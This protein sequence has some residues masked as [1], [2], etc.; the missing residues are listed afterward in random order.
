MQ[1]KLL[2][3]NLSGL[4]VE[5]RMGANKREQRRQARTSE[6]KREQARTSEKNAGAGEFVGAGLNMT[7]LL[8]S[9]SSP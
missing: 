3:Q 1:A 7:S 8:A 2:G 6:N 9:L 4:E 5:V